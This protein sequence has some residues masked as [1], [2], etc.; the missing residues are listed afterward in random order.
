MSRPPLCA[1]R[2]GAH[3]RALRLH[4]AHARHRGSPRRH[5]APARRRVPTRDEAGGDAAGQRARQAGHTAGGRHHGVQLPRAPLTPPRPPRRCPACSRR[6]DRGARPRRQV[7]RAAFQLRRAPSH[8]RHRAAS[9]ALAVARVQV[10][11]ARPAPRR[12]RSMVALRRRARTGPPPRSVAGRAG[13]RAGAA[14]EGGTRG[15]AS[16]QKSFFLYHAVSCASSC[17]PP[18]RPTRS[19]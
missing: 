5:A 3:S 17:T 6:R 9:A 18:P 12:P 19:A 10:R 14:R 4:P 13:P 2:C 11:R 16:G 8:A 15:L 1:G 7:P